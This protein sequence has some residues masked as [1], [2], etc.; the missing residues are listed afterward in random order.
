[1]LSNQA[2]IEDLFFLIV[3]SIVLTYGKRF[4]S[5]NLRLDMSPG[6]WQVPASRP[7]GKPMGDPIRG[8]GSSVG[9]D[10]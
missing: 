8:S 3:F 9:M 10:P 7:M 1:V 2:I 4:I 6:H 5:P